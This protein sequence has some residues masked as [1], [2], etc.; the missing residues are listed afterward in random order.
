[1]S[2]LTELQIQ[3]M[4]LEEEIR[5]EEEILYEIMENEYEMWRYGDRD[6]Y[7]KILGQK[8]VNNQKEYI[9]LLKNKL[10]ELNDC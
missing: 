4:N 3:A 10:Y 7:D 6:T 2:N 9:K 1:M 8:R 5:R